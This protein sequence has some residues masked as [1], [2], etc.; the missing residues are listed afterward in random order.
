MELEKGI[1]KTIILHNG[2][3]R[4]IFNRKIKHSQK[5]KKY[6]FCM[7]IRAFEE[8]H[9]APPKF[10]NTELLERTE[11]FAPP[12]VANVVFVLRGR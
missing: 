11:L 6:E 8:P 12:P 9:V 7:L 3:K 10:T 4:L 1:N 2:F 5:I